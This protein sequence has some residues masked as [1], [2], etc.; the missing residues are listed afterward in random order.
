MGQE[1]ES[2]G[3]ASQA[4]LR[5]EEGGDH[6]REDVCAPTESMIFVC[7]FKNDFFKKAKSF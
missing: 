7:C 4:E 5:Q 6:A 2:E 1:D 3:R